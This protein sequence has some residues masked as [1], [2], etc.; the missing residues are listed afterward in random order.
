MQIRLN[1]ACCYELDILR[2][3]LA[4]VTDKNG[5][6]TKPSTMIL[7]TTALIELADAAERDPQAV[8]GRLVEIKLNDGERFQEWARDPD[9][10][11]PADPQNNA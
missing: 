11:K 3:A 7:V 1:L 4:D 9:E 10:P 8:M 6:R 2:E 5:M